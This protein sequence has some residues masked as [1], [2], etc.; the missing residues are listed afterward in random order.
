MKN[1]VAFG[2]CEHK[3]KLVINTAKMC[4]HVCSFVR[5][6]SDQ[7]NTM[8]FFESNKKRLNKT[9]QKH[10]KHLGNWKSL[11][12]S[13]QTLL[14]DFKIKR[15]GNRGRVFAQE[16]RFSIVFTYLALEI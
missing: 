13:F 6:G 1:H 8:Q 9:K 2:K 3:T 4:K 7:G 10:E 12:F 14:P 5:S 16:L 11:L 15:I